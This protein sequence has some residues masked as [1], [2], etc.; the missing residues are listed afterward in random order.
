MRRACV[1]FVATLIA[2]GLSAQDSIPPEEAAAIACAHEVF[3]SVADV[4][5]E[6]KDAPFSIILVASETEFLL[7]RSAAP[8]T[9]SRLDESI[10]GFGVHRRQR[11]FSPNLLATFP[12]LSAEPTIVVGTRAA[13][14]KTSTEWLFVLLHEHFHQLQYSQPGYY[15]AAEA[16][17]LS[18]GDTTGMWMLNY[19]FPYSDAA[20]QQRFSRLGRSLSAAVKS[21]GT[22]RFA[23]TLREVKSAWRD[24]RQALRPN[25]YAYFRF[26]RGR[27]V[28]RG[29]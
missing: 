22:A 9:F 14:G 7:T 1:V 13:T 20:V 28:W 18:G 2:W 23:E 5:P 15:A 4:W 19:D 17:N 10:A 12:A 11:T 21:R 16:L 26:Q 24:F 8:P 6:W 27:K 25:D 29:T 3:A